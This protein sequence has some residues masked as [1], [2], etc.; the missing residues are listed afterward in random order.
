MEPTKVN[1]ETML[2]RRLEKMS[3]EPK[4]IPR[5]IKD[6]M[7][8]FFDNPSADLTQIND[9]LLGLGWDDIKI[10]YRTYELAR[11]YFEINE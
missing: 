10:D 4:S 8:S 2:I 5:L 6:I 3:V 9:Y 1:Y 11:T 7:N